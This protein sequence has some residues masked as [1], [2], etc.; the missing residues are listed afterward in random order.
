MKLTPHEVLLIVS[1]FGVALVAFHVFQVG[2][3]MRDALACRIKRV[4]LGIPTYVAVVYICREHGYQVITA[5]VA[6][7][8]ATLIATRMLVRTISPYPPAVHP[9]P[10]QKSFARENEATGAAASHTP[11][12]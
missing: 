3:R 9:S 2:K 11:L 6:G 4:L 12:A 1:G 10:P 8:V 5:V 7:L